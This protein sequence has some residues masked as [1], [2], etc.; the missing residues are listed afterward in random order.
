MTLGRAL[1]T[2][3]GRALGPQ[4]VSSVIGRL[5]PFPTALLKG[6]PGYRRCSTGV[7]AYRT[8]ARD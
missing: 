6:L 3:S 4:R 5:P 1:V 8:L 2:K 7:E